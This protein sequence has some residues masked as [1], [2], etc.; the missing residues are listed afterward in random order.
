[1]VV[2]FLFNWVSAFTAVFSHRLGECWGS[3]LS[4]IFRNILGIPVWAF[5]IALAIRTRSS[6]WFTPDPVFKVLGW[7]L[8]S[9]GCGIILL[10]LNAIRWRAAMPSIRDELV[11]DGIYAHIRHPIHAGT[12]LEMAGLWVL[13]PT[14]AVTLACG[15]WLIWVF[16]QTRLEEIDLVQ[17]I[18]GYREY[19]DRI[20]RFLPHFW[21][22]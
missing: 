20:P 19:M 1:M 16:I 21:A 7:V 18:R 11:Q 14:R 15:L 3:R 2:G 8:I 9:S 5:G 13:F 6:R 4:F 17:R 22:K 10:G 12:F